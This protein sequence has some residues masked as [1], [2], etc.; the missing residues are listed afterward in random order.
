MEKRAPETLALSHLSALFREKKHGELYEELKKNISSLHSHVSQ[1]GEKETLSDLY[2]CLGIL[3]FDLMN[4][5]D[6][7]KQFLCAIQRDPDNLAARLLLCSAFVE[8]GRFDAAKMESAPLRASSY[9]P[10][11]LHSVLSR[12]YQNESRLSRALYHWKKVVHETGT[13]KR[14]LSRLHFLESEV[15]IQ[16]NFSSYSTAHYE[17]SYEPVFEKNRERILSPLLSMV[18]QARWSLNRRFKA[19]P[20]DTTKIVIYREESF[21]SLLG[22]NDPNTEAF[23]S[24]DDGKLRIALRGEETTDISNLRPVIFHEYVH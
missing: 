22:N 19:S 15:H 8:Q 17:V 20:R 21:H 14:N 16:Q 24:F 10:V 23:F 13:T 9:Y 11:L 6:A 2:C 4:F 7:E 18:D 3:H 5:S 1:N 12:I